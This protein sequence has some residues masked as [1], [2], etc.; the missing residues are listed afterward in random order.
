VTLNYFVLAVLYYFDSIVRHFR[1]L[2]GAFFSNHR[3]EPFYKKM[4]LATKIQNSKSLSLG[5][6]YSH[7]IFIHRQFHEPFWAIA[8]YPTHTREKH[9]R[10]NETAR[11]HISS[12]VFILMTW[13]IFHFSF[14]QRRVAAGSSSNGIF[15]SL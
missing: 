11:T 15:E 4:C 13:I 2:S 6:C 12:A 3:F 10:H 1:V 8:E 5:M 9:C 14:S 7:H